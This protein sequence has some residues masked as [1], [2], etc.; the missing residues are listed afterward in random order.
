MVVGC[1]TAIAV[2]AVAGRTSLPDAGAGGA[3]HSGDGRPTSD[4]P[5]TARSAP[6]CCPVL[7]VPTRDPGS[8]GA[9]SLVGGG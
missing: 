3:A 2:I 9:G 7:A 4:P 1:L 6:S 8:V 5:V